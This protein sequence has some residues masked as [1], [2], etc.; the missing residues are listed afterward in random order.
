MR[1]ALVI[2]AVLVGTLALPMVPALS[3]RS[4]KRGAQDQPQKMLPKV[5]QEMLA[6]MVSPSLFGA[7]PG[8]F[9]KMRTAVSVSLASPSM[10]TNLFVEIIQRMMGMGVW[11]EE[12]TVIAARPFDPTFVE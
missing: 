8:Y 12:V 7:T 11:P 9:S 3:T 2:L 4:S 1:T 10:A 6:E 5:S